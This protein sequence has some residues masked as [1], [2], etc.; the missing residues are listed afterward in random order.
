[1]ASPR[2]HPVLVAALVGA[3][4][5]AALLGGC[6]QAAYRPD[7]AA[8]PYP[9]ERHRTQSVDVQVFR[10]DTEIVVVNAT[11]RAFPAST[12]WLNQRWRREVD[13]IPAGGVQRISLWGFRDD[14]GHLFNAGGFFRTERADPLRLVQ[15]ELPGDEPLVGFVVAREGDD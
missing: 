10:E 11:P 15:L 8:P 2:P 5:A 13:P 12:M 1:M 6:R 7:L 4:F 9:I 14:R 3:A